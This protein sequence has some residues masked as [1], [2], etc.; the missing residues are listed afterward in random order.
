MKLV[1]FYLSILV[2]LLSRLNPSPLED[3]S[4]S[5]VTGEAPHSVRF[6]PPR[7]YL[8]AGDLLHPSNYSIRRLKLSLSS[9]SVQ[10]T[11]SKSAWIIILL[12]AGD[13]ELNPGPNWKYPCGACSGPV[14]S[15]QK[16]I[17]CDVCTTWF[18]SRCIGLSDQ[19]YSTLQDSP[20]TWACRICLSKTLPFQ[21]TSSLPSPTT[22]P[23]RKCMRPTQIS[24]PNQNS[25]NILY[26][27]C[28]SLFPKVDELRCLT[29]QQL[30]HIICLCETW[31][32]DTILDGELF[33]P[34]FSLVRRDRSR[35]GGGIAIFVHDSTPFKVLSNYSSWS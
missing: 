27:N 21:D 14:K 25:L 2:S 12:L 30:P 16:G 11:K 6:A 33:I 26:T 9:R 29:S 19:E 22:S 31:L 15:N 3:P 10:I 34:S 4:Q 13:I 1:L 35:H 17:Y 5:S 8:N 20:D 18:H 28:R 24:T 23:S 32:D 7:I